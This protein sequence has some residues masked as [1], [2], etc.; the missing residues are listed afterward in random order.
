MGQI[1]AYH[2]DVSCSAGESCLVM[3][4]VGNESSDSD[5]IPVKLPSPVAI[6]SGGSIFICRLGVVFNAFRQDTA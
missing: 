6:F 5:S 2:V 1:C 3:K 4:D